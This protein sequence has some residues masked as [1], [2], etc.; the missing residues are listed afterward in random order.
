MNIERPWI[1]KRFFSKTLFYFAAV[2]IWV[3]Y[4]GGAGA[5]MKTETVNLPKTIG[6]W[7]RSDSVQIID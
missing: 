4:L 3:S 6:I 1:M 7:S 2:V 5:E